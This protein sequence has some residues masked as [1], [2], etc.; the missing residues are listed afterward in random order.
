MCLH[1]HRRKWEDFIDCVSGNKC[2]DAVSNNSSRNGHPY[3]F[4]ALSS[5]VIVNL[6][7]V[8]IYLRA[9]GVSHHQS[10]SDIFRIILE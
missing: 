4:S 10:S 2:K 6:I 7:E 1:K 9:A 8:W 5:Q 3:C